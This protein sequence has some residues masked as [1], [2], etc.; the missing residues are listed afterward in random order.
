M[1]QAAG[2]NSDSILSTL[3][4][5]QLGVFFDEFF[6]AATGEAYGDAAVI[7]IVALDA[8]YGA[9]A[10]FGMANFAAEHGIGVCAAAR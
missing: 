4:G 1:H 6:C 9:D 8:Y 7:V 3:S 10:E 5:L 2:K